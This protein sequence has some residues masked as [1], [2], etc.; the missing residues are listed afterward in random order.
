MRTL[1]DGSTLLVPILGDP[2][3]QVK[4]P[5][6]LTAE[7][8]RLGRNTMVVPFHVAGDD[9]KQVVTSLH[10]VRNITG[11]IATAPHKFSASKQC[12]TLTSRAKI[13]GAASLV[14]RS[15][16]G[17][18]HGDLTDGL[19]FVRGIEAGG[20]HPAGGR[21]L[22]VGAGGAGSAIAF[23]LLDAGVR[24]LA[25]YDF[26]R[27]KLSELM[28]R[29]DL[30]HPGKVVPGSINPTGFDLVVNATPLGMRADDPL[31]IEI[32]KLTPSTF[33]A[34]V[35]T[36]PEIT[37]LLAAAQAIGCNIQTGVG[38]FASAMKLM[39]EFF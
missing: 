17:G 32:A 29:L 39:V 10:S 15:N 6:L 37:P 28:A 20:Y 9:F 35:V 19:G 22:L 23:A 24:Q 33:V 27:D 3:F 11:F 2:I 4:A 16:N 38:F 13:A 5:A 34:D 14:R 1:L 12:A 25:I 18:W 7:F 21:A 8:V 30:I 26:D 31:P 36:S